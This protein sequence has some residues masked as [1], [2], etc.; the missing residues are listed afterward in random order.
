M[1]D[2]YSPP[3]LTGFN[4]SP[5]SDDGSEVDS[6]QL[7]W[8][9]HLS[10]LANP[11]KTF[12]QAINTAVS[13]RFSVTPDYSE[14]A[15]E[16]T[17]GLIIVDGTYRV[18]NVKRYGA[19][20]DGTTDDSIAF[21]ALLIAGGFRVYIPAGTYIVDS[22]ISA[23][24]GILVGSDTS[25]YCE[26]GVTIT[27][28]DSGM[29]ANR[30]FIRFRDVNNIAFT[31]NNSIWQYNTKPTA[32]E[33]RHIFHVAGATNFQMRDVVAKKAGGD[34]IVIGNGAVK[35][36]AENIRITNFRSDNCRR[37]GLTILSAIDCVVN[38]AIL[39]NSD[40]TNP[41]NGVAIEPNV[42]TDELKGIRLNDITTRNCAGAGMYMTINDLPADYELDIIINNHFDDGSLGDG[43]QFQHG[44][45]MLGRVQYNDGYLLNS[46]NSG[47]YVKNW[48]SNS[49]LLNI[50]RPTI[51]NPNE[52]ND[53]TNGQIGNGIVVYAPN[54][55]DNDDIGNV[56]IREPKCVDNRGTAQMKN[57][58][59]GQTNV[60]GGTVRD[61][62]ILDPIE[63]SGVGS[64]HDQVSL[65][66]V[67][68]YLVTDSRRILKRDNTANGNVS[69]SD[70]YSIETNR[71][72]SG[73][74]TLTLDD[75]IH[76]GPSLFT[77]E[78][79]EAQ[80]LRI[81]PEAGALILAGGALGVYIASSTIGD[82]LTLRKGTRHSATFEDGD[83]NTTDDRITITSHPFTDVETVV[84][85]TT[86]VLPA[87]SNQGDVYYVKSHDANT[88]ELYTNSGLSSK[89]DITAAAGTGTHTVA[90]LAWYI[91]EKQ[92]AWS[93]STGHKSI[94]SLGTTGGAGSAGAGNQTV[95]VEIDGTSYALL[96]D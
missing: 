93:F 71:G 88:V 5:P 81:D 20:G 27:I 15:A 6:N 12:A 43:M 85:T 49:S 32:D 13:N 24:D 84:L 66:S 86:G 83:V 60:T 38:G 87:G 50:N 76:P 39:E 46:G 41:K 64:G 95:A 8:A 30:G 59:L 4:A 79:R 56:T 65:I 90:A 55:D 69:I 14:T 44:T 42:S 63:I 31:G 2:S 70:H 21:N 96:H 80:E 37:S 1:A 52:N 19:A 33:Q 47:I 78:V 28:P 75:D 11:L 3:S 9:K 23:T 57:G 58:I 51:I 54:T 74:I 18:G 61:I 72:A 35:N 45:Q 22:L 67:V 40:G 7:T 53:T 92:G 26:P 16:T 34:G 62:S 29:A 82:S 73:T 94:L 91:V 48:K 25:I 89:V 68:N 36:Y 17:A 10:K 77:F